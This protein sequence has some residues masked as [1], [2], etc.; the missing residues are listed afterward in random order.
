MIERRPLTRVDF[1]TIRDSDEWGTV[2]R[3]HEI[4]SALLDY[5][6]NSFDEALE[7][8]CGSGHNSKT[9]ASYCGH[10]TA[11]EFDAAKLQ[12]SDDEK[13]TFIVADAQDLSAFPDSSMDLIFSSNLIEHLPD[14]D[15][16]LCEC[17]RVVKPDGIIVH[18]V[19][20]NTWKTFN[21][22]LFYPALAMQLAAR[23]LGRRRSGGGSPT[24]VDAPAALS[25]NLQPVA[26]SG[27]ALHKLAPRV[28]G[29]SCNHV[30][31]IWNWRERRWRNVFGRN[32]LE[33]VR[34]VRLPFYF[35][36]GY[37][38]RT[39]LRLGN[40]VGLSS[41]TAYI[42]SRPKSAGHATD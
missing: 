31:E 1:R 10:L 21:L 5:S 14:V 22:L 23:L 9:L 26:R 19:P 41:C 33:I 40:Y 13:T 38:F 3:D 42:L 36:H 16:C 6:D 12:A 34:V 15:R 20:N 7:L 2:L 24:V 28:H 30:Q 4:R 39:L 11:T 29:I 27:F 8:G 25:D 18:T 35:G 37:R 32:G 17:R